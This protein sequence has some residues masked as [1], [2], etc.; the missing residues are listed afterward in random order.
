MCVCACVHIIVRVLRVCVGGRVWLRVCP[1]VCACVC[2][3]AG[4]RAYSGLSVN[5][6]H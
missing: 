1:C 4:V 5:A 2:M 6:G 3:R